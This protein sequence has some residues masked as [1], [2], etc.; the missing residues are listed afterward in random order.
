MFRLKI[1]TLILIFSSL[2]VFTSIIKNQTRIL[3]KNIYNFNN[4]INNKEKEFNETQLDFF[5]VTSPSM[6]EKKVKDLSN[7]NYLPMEY[8]N[9]FLSLRSFLSLKNK[10][11]IQ[12]NQ[13]EKKTQKK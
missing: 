3:E 13:N 1:L 9:I 11:V 12:E 7:I 8:S 5:Y 2:L 6:I 10:Y 4:L